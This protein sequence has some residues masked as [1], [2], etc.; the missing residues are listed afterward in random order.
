MVVFFPNSNA[1]FLFWKELSESL[2]TMFY[3]KLKIYEKAYFLYENIFS[4]QS[5]LSL[6]NFLFKQY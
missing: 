6:T 4:H 1:Y 5:L 3:L 2:V